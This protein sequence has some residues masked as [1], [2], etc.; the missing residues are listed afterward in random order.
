MNIITN[1]AYIDSKALSGSFPSRHSA[2]EYGNY[3]FSR[4]L[5][6]SRCIDSREQS[7][8]S[9]S[10]RTSPCRGLLAVNVPPLPAGFYYGHFELVSV[11]LLQVVILH[12]PSRISFKMPS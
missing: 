7:L 10:T 6:C 2:R 5:R 8:L 3:L 11:P 12:C 4:P 9:V 1:C